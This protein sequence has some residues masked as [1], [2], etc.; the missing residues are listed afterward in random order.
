MPTGL[1]VIWDGIKYETLFGKVILPGLGAVFCIMAIALVSAGAGFLFGLAPALR[2]SRPDLHAV[3]RDAGASAT[4]GR[5]GRRLSGVLVIGEVALTVVLL[6]GAGVMIHSF[7]NLYTAD[8]GAQTA[9]TVEM[10][11]L[12]LGMMDAEFTVTE[13]PE[14][15]TRL[16]K[17]AAR[18]A[19]A[20]RN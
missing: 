4:G 13:P 5:H 15:L 19:S 6:A 10:L 11:A 20:A 16:R 17:L 7:L 18:F 8:I 12:Y 9:N 2:F 3:L 1:W 14:L